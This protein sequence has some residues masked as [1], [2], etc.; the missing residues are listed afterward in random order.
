MTCL[1]RNVDLVHDFFSQCSLPG[2]CLQTKWSSRPRWPAMKAKRERNDDDDGDEEDAY[3]L[4]I[5][6]KLLLR[7]SMSK[8]LNSVAN[9]SACVFVCVHPKKNTNTHT[10]SIFKWLS[11]I[12]RRELWCFAAATN[13]AI[14]DT[15]CT[16]CCCLLRLIWLYGRWM[17]CTSRTRLSQIHSYHIL[18]LALS[19]THFVSCLWFTS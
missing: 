13:N 12:P 5:L 2:G 3:M 18:S 1:M 10:I 15:F 17:Q 4:A 16:C 14:L 9:Q 11:F 19:F 6:T 7:T 8:R